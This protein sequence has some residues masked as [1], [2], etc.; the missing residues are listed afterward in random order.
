[1]SRQVFRKPYRLDER[2][3]SSFAVLKEQICDQW[4]E[5]RGTNLGVKSGTEV[6]DDILLSKL[7]YLVQQLNAAAVSPWTPN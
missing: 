5:L 2:V 4:A 7:H 6:V 1:M 3:C